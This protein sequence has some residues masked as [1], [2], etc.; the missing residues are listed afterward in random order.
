M[1]DD[2]DL[3]RSWEGRGVHLHDALDDAW[4]NAQKDGAGPGTYVVESISIE[5]ENPIRT[6]IVIIG[7][8]E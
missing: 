3:T 1:M 7:P 2:D 4:K 8:G 6:Y 5:T